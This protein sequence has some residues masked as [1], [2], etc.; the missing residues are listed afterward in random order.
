MA[1]GGGFG[2]SAGARKERGKLAG[3][4]ALEGAASRRR[5]G[6]DAKETSLLAGEQGWKGDRPKAMVKGA[7]LGWVERVRSGQAGAKAGVWKK[8]RGR[9][10]KE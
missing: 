4:E 9:G 2:A 10:P 3:V 5:G 7:K 6:V 8:E 1:L